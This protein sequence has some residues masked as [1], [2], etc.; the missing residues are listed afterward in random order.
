MFERKIVE[1]LAARMQEDDSPLIQVVAGPRQTGKSTAIAQALEK[2][3]KTAHS[4]SADDVI[5][6]DV[7]W[8][9]TEWQQAR[10]LQ[11]D[12][13]KP[14]VLVLDE[15]QKVHGWPNVVKGLWDA[16]QRERLPLKVVLSGSSSLLLRKGLED[17]LKGRFEVLRSTHW[18]LA[19][20][21][22][23]FGFTLDDFLFFGGFPGAARL[24]SDERRWRAYMRD[25]I[26]EPTI[27]N[28]VLEQEDVRKPAL[29]RALFELGARFSGQELSYNKML[30]QLQDAGN[31]TTLAHY[32]TLLDKAGVLCGLEKYHP[33]VLE[34]RKSSPRLMVYDTALMT[35]VSGRAKE[36]LLGDSELRGHLVESAVGARL[37]ALGPDHG[38]DVQWWREG[39]DE[40]DFVLAGE[41]KLAAVEVK[42]GRTKSQGGMAAFLREYPEATR[43]VVGGSAAGAVTVED[44]LLGNVALPWS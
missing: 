18:S 11:R 25:S 21:R 34:R 13:G 22:E 24:I 42:S 44:F 31:T 4:A 2:V 8:L 20:C 14:A 38:F 23:A 41:G 33:R 36:L 12:S 15:V 7:E 37:L 16:D 10:N 39:N 40:V 43:I 32:L 9:R 29:M 19:E 27:S 6:P 5:A 35:A 30:G 3:D 26:I 1:T 17:S 28:D